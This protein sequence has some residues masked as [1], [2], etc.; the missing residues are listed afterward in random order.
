LLLSGFFPQCLC[1]VGAGVVE[2]A[3]GW[4]SLRGVV[5]HRVCFTSQPTAGGAEAGMRLVRPPARA[6]LVLM[7]VVGSSDD[8]MHGAGARRAAKCSL[9]DVCTLSFTEGGVG[10]I[11]MRRCTA[12][13][14]MRAFSAVHRRAH[15]ASSRARAATASATNL[16]A[17]RRGACVYS[18]LVHRRAHRA[19]SRARAASASATNVCAR[20]RGACVYLLLVHRRAHR[21]SS[22]A[23]AASSSAQSQGA[24]AR[25][26]S[27]CGLHRRVHRASP[28][29][30]DA[31]FPAESNAHGAEARARIHGCD[32]DALTQALLGR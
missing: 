12:Q 17:R 25:S 11:D 8:G 13:R 30:R 32:F 18:L 27:L 15:R 21:A 4:K 28:R 23:W 5:R 6:P 26:R 2:L 7:G 29:L 9:L 3:P 1:L 19:S 16:R 22:R 10:I 24:E 31:S 20:R 14:R